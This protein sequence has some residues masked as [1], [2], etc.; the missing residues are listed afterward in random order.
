MGLISSIYSRQ[1]QLIANTENALQEYKKQF[2]V[3]I[4][5]NMTLEKAQNRLKELEEL[6]QTPQTPQ[7]AL[8]NITEQI[9]LDRIIMIFKINGIKVKK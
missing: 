2:G 4:E 6:Q 7:Q 9:E 3:I 8:E 5:E 1:K